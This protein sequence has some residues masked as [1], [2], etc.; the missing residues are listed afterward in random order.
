LGEEFA[1]VYTFNNA[2]FEKFGVG[3]EFDE[4]EASAEGDV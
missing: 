3:F 2:V 4:G 1:E